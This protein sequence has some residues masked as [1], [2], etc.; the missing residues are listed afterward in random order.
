MIMRKKYDK[1]AKTIRVITVPPIMVLALLL[2]AYWLRRDV[3]Q[4]TSEL[5]LSILF[6]MVIPISTYPL[7]LVIPK[8]KHEG[9]EGQRNI[10]FIMNIIGYAGV[11]IWGWFAHVSDVLM[12]IHLTYFFSVCILLLFNKVFKIRASGHACSIAGPLI[13]LVY[14]LGWAAFVPCA[15]LFAAIVWA[16]LYAKRHTPKELFWGALCAGIAL[17]VSFIPMRFRLPLCFMY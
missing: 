2:L 11:V 7:A 12:Q 15:L 16:S 3:F 5:L 6:L 4:S 13:L 9:R 14:L 8:Y 10:A 17:C 1:L